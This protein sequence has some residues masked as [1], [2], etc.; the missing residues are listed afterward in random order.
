MTESTQHSH[1]KRGISTRRR[2]I[3]IV[4]AATIGLAAALVIGEAGLRVYVASRGWTSNCYVTGLVFFVPHKRAGYTMRPNLRLKSSTYDVT[5]NSD[6]LR[7]TRPTERSRKEDP[8][9]HR[10]ILVLGGSS[11][12]GY[13][14]PDGQDSCV[15]LETRLNQLLAEPTNP[16]TVDVLNAGVPGYNIQQCRARFVDDLA[17][18]SPDIVLLYLGWNDSKH[19][20]SEQQI[21]VTPPAPPLWERM[22]AR[23]VLYGILRYRVFPPAAPKFASPLSAG[24][25]ARGKE[26]FAEQLRLLIEAIQAAGAQPVIATQLMAA[27]S[28][29][30]QLAK[31]LGQTE[32]QIDANREVGQWLTEHIR[33]VATQCGI[34]LIDVAES[35]ECDE[36]ILGDAIHLTRLGH[37]KV[38]NVWTESLYKLLLESADL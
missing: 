2:K 25:T 4:L 5:T 8:G 28:K 16:M 10:R 26:Y 23:S 12:F 37:E 20:I 38:A 32:E 3:F 17:Q 13:L 9:S 6:G 21:D 15:L 22:C 11:V 7:A 18:L 34:P 1:V 19:V 35:I 27:T 31:L 14:V 30:E 33:D 24:P 36:S 29:N